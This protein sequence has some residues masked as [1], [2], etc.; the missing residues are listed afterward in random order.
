MRCTS[1]KA[2]ECC[3]KSFDAYWTCTTD[4]K[5]VATRALI[6]LHVGATATRPGERKKL[7]LPHSPEKGVL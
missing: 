4:A 2:Q 3:R 6:K 5:P 1:A 7:E